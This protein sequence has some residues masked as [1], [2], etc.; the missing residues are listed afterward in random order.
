MSDQRRMYWPSAS[1]GLLADCSDRKDTWLCELA[2]G[3][4][5]GALSRLAQACP[6]SVPVEHVAHCGSCD[7]LAKR[8]GRLIR[9]DSNYFLISKLASITITPNISVYVGGIVPS[10]ALLPTISLNIAACK[11]CYFLPRKQ[12]QLPRR[13]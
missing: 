6:T 11:K 1:F 8:G 12:K 3:F 4:R 2:T 7:E 9:I 5:A 13:E 10:P